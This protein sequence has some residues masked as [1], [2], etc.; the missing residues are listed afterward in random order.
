MDSE[1]TDH[2]TLDSTLFTQLGSFSTPIVNL[3]TS[4]S[5]LITSS[6]NIPFNSN[7]TLNNVLC[8]SSFRLNLMYVGKI[9][10]ALR[11]AIFF[12]NFCILQ[13]LASRRMI[14]SGKQKGGLYYMS[15]LQQTP[16]S[17]QVS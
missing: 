8:V 9:T 12:P 15:S 16:I 13:D 14:G 7:I 1:A 11:R 5:T 3:P 2:I 4:S 10:N 17:H 6:S